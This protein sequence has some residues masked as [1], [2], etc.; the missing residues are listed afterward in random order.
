MTDYLP[1]GA[2]INTPANRAAMRNFMSL[3][4]ACRK[5]TV[6]EARASLCS[7]GHDLSIELGEIRG[8]IPKPEGA[9]GMDTG[10]TRELP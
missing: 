6:L 1:E 3:Q 8:I 7:A 4:E 9:L 5:G 2:R 10:E